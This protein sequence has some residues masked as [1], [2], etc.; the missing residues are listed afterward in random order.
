MGRRDSS[1]PASPG[2]RAD[3]MEV[4]DR[5]LG[6]RPEVTRGKMFGFPAFYAGGKLFACVY[7]DGAGLKLPQ[8]AI[9]TLEGK[10]GITPFQPY[11]KARMKEWIHI[12]HDQPGAFSEDAA[13]FQASIRFVSRTAKQP[14]RPPGSRKP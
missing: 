1:R 4:L 12:R 6:K 13:L 9:R 10:P 8:G 7:G 5:L 2:Y 3:V 11:G 14:K